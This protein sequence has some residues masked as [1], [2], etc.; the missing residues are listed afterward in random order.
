MGGLLSR[1]F[2]I[3]MG[4]Y[5]YLKD[6]SVELFIKRKHS[7]QKNNYI[8]YI[9]YKSNFIS[10]NKSYKLQI[11]YFDSNILQNNVEKIAL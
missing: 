4:K 11:N 2:F 5:L 1:Q 9:F 3:I 7:L 8:K 6:S 10:P